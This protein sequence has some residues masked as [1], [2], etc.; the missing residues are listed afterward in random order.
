M[1]NT[2]GGVFAFS[3]VMSY[4]SC[5]IYAQSAIIW[6]TGLTYCNLVNMQNTTGGVFCI[7]SPI[8]HTHQWYHTSREPP[9]THS[10]VT[11]HT[12]TFFDETRQYV[13]PISVKNEIWKCILFSSLRCPRYD[14]P[15]S[16]FHVLQRHYMNPF[17]LLRVSWSQTR[18]GPSSSGWWASATTVRTLGSLR[19][20]WCC[21]SICYV[22]NNM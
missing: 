2:T 21:L 16:E 19:T 13:R 7:F 4:L 8:I 3:L 12:G 11:S 6:R 5:S 15:W 20:H 18:F 9:S 10:P 1:Q 17:P 14:W 22:D